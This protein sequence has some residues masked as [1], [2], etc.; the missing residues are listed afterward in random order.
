MELAFFF[1]SYIYGAAAKKV[2]L[3]CEQENGNIYGG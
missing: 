3:Y 1:M 2:Y